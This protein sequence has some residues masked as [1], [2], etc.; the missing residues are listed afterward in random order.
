MAVVRVLGAELYYERHG[1]GPA[2]L[3]AH[4][5]GGNALSWWQQVP[6]FRD[7]YTCIVIDQPGFGRSAEPEGDDWTFVDCLAGLLEHLEI[8]RVRFVA[9]STGG[10]TCMGY[11]LRYP[12]RVAGLVMAGTLGP[13]ELPGLSEWYAEAIEIRTELRARGIHPA[14]GWRMAAERPALQFLYQQIG[15]LN[16]HLARPTGRRAGSG[17]RTLPRRSWATSGYRPYSRWVRRTR[18]CRRG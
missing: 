11:A 7:R 8:E 2:L 3:F 17:S 4:G 14:C 9:Q 6:Y 13:I 18:S 10:R 16:Q 1:A 12:E 15:G 5:V